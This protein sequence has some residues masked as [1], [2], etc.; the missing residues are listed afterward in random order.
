MAYSGSPIDYN[1]DYANVGITAAVWNT[2]TGQQRQNVFSDYVQ[3]SQ[4]PDNPYKTPSKDTS[5]PSAGMTP[6]Q[7]QA[8]NDAITKALQGNSDYQ[9]YGGGQ[10]ASA[11]LNAYQTGD[12][13]G[14]VSLSGKPFTDDQQKAAV[15]SADAA[16]APAYREQA[17]ND[18]AA[19]TQTLQQE[20]SGFKDFQRGDQKTF[21]TDKTTLDQNAADQGVLFSGS[22]AQK[23][24]DLRT[25]YADR[26][27]AQRAATAGNISSTARGYQY[28][29][30]NDAAN[31][32]SALYALPGATNFNATTGRATPASSI[33]STYNP[34][35]YNFQGRA[36][37]A[38]S[39]A[40]QTRAAGL[41]ANNANKLS[42]SGV[43]AK[44]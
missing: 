23:L 6:A 8:M 28:Q 36:P 35:A 37:V 44:F 27:S 32:L 39:A 25:T 43:G 4:S 1:P 16:L 9:T 33:S 13:S 40:V 34:S 19:A 7:I 20:Q 12:W 31:G 29:Y 15:A 26:E 3:K 10:D 38:Q 21:G 14:V 30:G 17:A 5:S 42:L 2:L 22:R 41:L 18:R 11:I 24:S